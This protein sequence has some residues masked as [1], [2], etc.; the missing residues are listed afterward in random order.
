MHS[1]KKLAVL[2]NVRLRI[3]AGL[4]ESVDEKALTAFEREFEKYSWV[5]MENGKIV[6]KEHKEGSPEIQLV[7]DIEDPE[8][9]ATFNL[10]PCYFK[11]DMDVTMIKRMFLKILVHPSIDFIYWDNENNTD[12]IFFTET[13]PVVKRVFSVWYGMNI[14]LAAFEEEE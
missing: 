9:V 1:N 13:G 2:G 12:I 4:I 5:L 14:A 11:K 8:T 3:W 7:I 10:L 6:N